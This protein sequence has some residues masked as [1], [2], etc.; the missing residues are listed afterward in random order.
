M[1]DILLDKFKE[2][3]K[4]TR[5]VDVFAGSGIVFASIF[6]SDFPFV[7]EIIVNDKEE[8]VFNLLKYINNNNQEILIKNFKKIINEYR[9]FSGREVNKDS[10]NK[11]KDS[12]NIIAKKLHKTEKD[13]N[14]MNKFIFVLVLYG[15]NQ[16]IRF[17]SKGEFNIPAGKYI[18]AF[19]IQQKIKSFKDLINDNKKIISFKNADFRTLINEILDKKESLENTLFYFDPPYLLAKETYNEI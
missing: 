6:K 14:K 8:T 9:L 3:K 17:N 2:Q 15:F 1:I 16:Q 5:F 4:I 10:Y 12:Y 11:L 19:Y 7:K 13:K 18:N